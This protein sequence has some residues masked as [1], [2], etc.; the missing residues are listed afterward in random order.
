MSLTCFL[1]L[2]PESNR[3]VRHHAENFHKEKAQQDKLKEVKARLNFEGCSGKNSKV[4]EVSQHSESSTPDVRGDLR[5]RLRR[6]KP[7]PRKRYHNG[8]S[9]RRTE[10]FS[11]SEDS[12]GGHWKSRSK[13]Q[14]SSIEEDDLSQP[15]VCEETYPFTPRIRYFDFPK[16]TQ[17]PTAKVKRWAMPTWCHMFNSTLTESARGRSGGFQPGVKE[18]TSD[19]EATR[20]PAKAKFRQKGRL[21]EPAKEL[22]QGSEKDQP[23]TTKKG[24]ASGKDKAMTILMVQ[25]WQ[26]VARQRVTQSFSLDPEISFPPL[27]DEDRAEGPMIIEA[28]LGVKIEDAKHSTSTWMNFFVVRSPSPYNGIIGRPGVRKIQA[29]PS[30]AYGMFKLLEAQPSAITRAAKERIKVS[31]HLEYPEQTIAIGST[32]MEEGRKDLC[33]LGVTGHIRL[34]TSGHDWCFAAY[35]GAS[36]EHSRRMSSSQTKDKK[37]STREKLGNIRGS[38]KTFRRRHHE[39]SPLPRLVIKFGNGKKA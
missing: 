38:R 5:R 34:E 22:K 4:Q 9:S 12:G 20:N 32:L 14:K 15:W 3:G 26:R 11:E 7:I 36:V 10:S 33:D 18:N 29:V 39:G 37:P 25:P 13:K 23:K 35:S 27:G 31:I 21:Q 28:E 2:T 16:K 24:E 30:T 6:T 1:T 17:M 19:M 8:T